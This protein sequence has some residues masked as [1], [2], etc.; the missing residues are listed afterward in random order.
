MFGNSS[1]GGSGPDTAIVVA[2]DGGVEFE[3]FGST[4][5][6]NC[7]LPF[8]LTSPTSAD[9]VAGSTCVDSSMGQWTFQSGTATLN[10]SGCVMTVTTSGTV[11]DPG[12]GAGTFT[13]S[14]TLDL[15]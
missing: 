5:L 9:V 12:M 7:V 13:T 15:Q 2:T 8:T 11:V 6:P 10:A 4:A 3:A 1:S 14:S